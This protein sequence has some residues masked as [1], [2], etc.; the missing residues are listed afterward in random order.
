[1]KSPSNHPSPI[2]TWQAGQF[3]HQQGRLPQDL[4]FPVLHAGHCEEEKVQRKPK[5]P[6]HCQQPET[7]TPDPPGTQTAPGKFQDRILF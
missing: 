7:W 4:Q 6:P 3:R 2:L 5:D 1:M